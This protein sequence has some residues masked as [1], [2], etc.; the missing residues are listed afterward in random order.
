[1]RKYLVNKHG[2]ET[3]SAV[4]KPTERNGNARLPDVFGN[5]DVDDADDP[6]CLIPQQ[7]I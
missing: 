1:M 3:V 7:N 4:A 6:Y 5:A 2:I